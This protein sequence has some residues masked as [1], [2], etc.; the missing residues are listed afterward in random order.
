MWTLRTRISAL[1]GAIIW[2][3]FFNFNLNIDGVQI[4]LG[5]INVASSTVQAVESLVETTLG[6]FLAVTTNNLLTN[7]LS[8]RMTNVKGCSTEPFVHAI[9]GHSRNDIVKEYSRKDD[10]YGLVLG[11]DNVWTFAD[12]KYFCLGAALGYVH[13]KTTPSDNFVLAK[14][15]GIVSEK[16]FDG[17]DSADI[18]ARCFGTDFRHDVYAV[19][20]FGAYESFNDKCLKTSIGVILGYNH[21]RNKFHMDIPDRLISD[22]AT[23]T[24]PLDIKFISS[25]ISLGVE[26]I[27]NLY[28]YEGYQFGLWFQANYAHVFQDVD[29]VEPELTI[30]G[31]DSNTYYDA[32]FSHDFLA[33]TIGLNVEKEAFKRA[34]KKLT[35]SLKAG[36]ECR[37]IQ[38]FNTRPVGLITTV[39]TDKDNDRYVQKPPSP[40]KNAAVI[41]F[42]ASQ[43]LNDHWSIAGSYS[44]RFN[45]DLLA[46]SLTGGVEY[47]F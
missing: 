38:N 40:R 20:L 22:D 3:L 33:T 9:Y 13:G 17:L 30:S 16:A 27:K 41:S 6:E 28:A 26:F 1:R 14:T 18:A 31:K 12:E 21:G 35:L 44:A 15:T 25:G 32:K 11:V 2:C 4:P 39:S 47:D 19:R 37:V 34:D 45:K 24:N 42:G 5:A 43:K 23:V 29:V 7:A 36:W 46:H 10:T 8:S